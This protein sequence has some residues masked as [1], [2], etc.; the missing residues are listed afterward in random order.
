MRALLQQTAALLLSYGFLLLGS[1]LFM[2]L[3][4]LRSTLE[5]FSTQITGLIMS[6]Y[7]LGL[8]AGARYTAYLVGKV[9]YIRTFSVCAS[10]VSVVPLAHMLLVDPLVWGALRFVTGFAM[11]AMVMVTES[12]LNSSVGNRQRGSLL[13]IYMVINYSAAGAAQ[14]LLLVRDI[15]GNELFVLASICFSLCL[16]PVALT[17][18]AEPAPA[19]AEPMRLKPTLRTTPVGFYCAMCAGFIGAAFYSMGPVFALKIGLDAQ[20]IAIF[21][22][23]GVIGGLALQTPIGKLSDR[24]ERRGVIAVLALLVVF[25]CLSLSWQ[26]HSAAIPF[27]V[28][29]GGFVFGSLSFTLYSLAA[30][31]ANDWVT[32]SARMQTAGALLAGYSIGAIS[33]PIISAQA[34]QWRG[35]AGM[36]ECMAACALVLVL[37]TTANLAGSRR[38]S[39]R[40]R[41]FVARPSSSFSSGELYRAVQAKAAPIEP[42]EE[43]LCLNFSAPT[44][45]DTPTTGELS[46]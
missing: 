40:K 32:Q 13:S 42:H 38:S 14:L 4:S 9:G 10:V 30:A 31:H 46:Q 16:V 25:S 2:T 23:L 28:F 7:Y 19:P 8:F 17:G 20:Q 34:M 11:A 29:C 35:A 33:G 1:G 18:T 26:A 24:I 22:A 21:M 43:Q 3:L 12:W 27:A 41:H 37:Y 15:Q 5:G 36:F 44:S 45:K 6:G 39:A